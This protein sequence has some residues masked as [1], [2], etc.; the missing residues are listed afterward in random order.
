M[1]NDYSDFMGI[2]GL[3][4]FLGLSVHGIY[5]MVREERIPG[6]KLDT[7]Y[8]FSKSEI[9]KWLESQRIG[10]KVN[11]FIISEPNQIPDKYE[12]KRILIE[13][14]KEEVKSRIKGNVEFNQTSYEDFEI[15]FNKNIRDEGLKELKKDGIYRRKNKKGKFVLRKE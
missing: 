11:E 1:N 14:F 6:Y 3:A 7:T 10:P 13:R 8:R 4:E 12:E 5:K 2:K 9:K 15:E